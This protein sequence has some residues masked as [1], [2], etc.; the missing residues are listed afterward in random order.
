MF[1]NITT[2]D[3][4][5][6]TAINSISVRKILPWLSSDGPTMTMTVAES[7]RPRKTPRTTQDD[8]AVEDGEE[9]GAASATHTVT[10]KVEDEI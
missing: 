9:E 2:N 5:F 8:E 10:P 7:G 3:I 4:G 6:G 1:L